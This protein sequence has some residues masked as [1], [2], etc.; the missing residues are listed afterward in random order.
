MK[1]SRL[2]FSC[3]E[4]LKELSLSDV[5]GAFV[6][7]TNG[8]SQEEKSTISLSCNL[9]SCCC[10]T[11][12]SIYELQKD[13][14]C[15]A[16]SEDK[17]VGPLYEECKENNKHKMD[18]INTNIIPSLNLIN[19]FYYDLLLLNQNKANSSWA[20]SAEWLKW[21]KNESQKLK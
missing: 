15:S 5:R 17:F 16:L 14:Y 10:S 9:K 19:F 3:L 11:S 21:C 1:N 2:G 4:K 18:K 12:T 20:I 7:P 6:I 13:F 8:I